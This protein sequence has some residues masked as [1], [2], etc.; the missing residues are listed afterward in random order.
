MLRVWGQHKKCFSWDIKR[1]GLTFILKSILF[2][3]SKTKPFNIRTDPYH[4]KN[5]MFGFR[6]PPPI[7]MINQ[8]KNNLLYFLD[9]MKTRSCSASSVGTRRTCP[10]SILPWT[11]FLKTIGIV[12]IARTTPRRLFRFQSHF[13]P[14]D[15]RSHIFYFLVTS[16]WCTTAAIWIPTIQIQ[17]TPWITATYQSPH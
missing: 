2:Y 12:R 5:N 13:F 11:Q 7:T 6:A 9:M 8:R 4:L 3:H 16:S 14:A 1:S 15:P 10:V 17:E